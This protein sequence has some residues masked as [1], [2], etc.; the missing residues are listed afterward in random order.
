MI[1]PHCSKAC[2]MAAALG[3]LF[4]ANGALRLG[5]SGVED[6]FRHWRAFDDFAIA[7]GYAADGHFPVAPYRVRDY[8]RRERDPRFRT[9]KDSLLAEISEK[10][11]RPTSFWKTFPPDAVTPDGR[12]LVASRFDDTGR[13]L[14]L[15]MAFT[16]LGG[17]A[18]F[19]LFWLGILAALPVLAWIALEFAAAGHRL[20]AV[21]FVAAASCSAFVL[22]LLSLGYSAVAFHLVGLL[23]LIALATYAVLGQPRAR[24]LHA[25]TAIS[26]ALIGICALCRGTVPFLLP[27]FALALLVGVRRAA[28]AASTAP[29]SD[30]LRRIGLWAGAMG[31]LMVPYVGFR[32][33]SDDL[34]A[35]TR[36]AYGRDQRPLYH[37]PALLF[38]KGLGD[39]D[40]TKGYQFGDKAGEDAIARLDPD[41][42]AHRAGEVRLRDTILGDVREDPLWL[43]GILAKRVAATVSL[44]KLW[45]WA[46][47]DGISFFPATSRNEGVTDNYYTLTKQADWFAIGPWSAEAP[48]PV[49]LAPV[50]ILMAAACVRAREGRLAILASRA[51][52][53]LLLLAC[54]ALAILPVPV[55]IT[56]ATALETECFV[57]VHFLALALLV[58][59]LR[60][61]SAVEYR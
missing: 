3:A 14:F 19:L 29:H 58:E 11:L 12:W 44:Y 9:F 16:A 35:T 28:L 34:V 61:L 37:D 36:D 40:R 49:L 30:R 54:L 20:T 57:L 43:A 25:P 52:R 51:R 47:R 31:L 33:W 1:L 27:A 13:A 60:A 45:P 21:I 6:V 18:P 15:G 5:R 48:V 26:G 4:L 8:V 59:S 39:F 22:D 46:P 32:A 7:A 17:A 50:L 23:V 53:A 38:W 41:Q 2:L 42:R 56:T 55:L 10:D 24:G